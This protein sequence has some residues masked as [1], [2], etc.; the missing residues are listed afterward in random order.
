MATY[1]PPDPKHSMRQNLMFLREYAKRVILEG[2]DSLTA[3]E[4]VKEALI[5]EVWRA[6]KS[7]H[8]TERDVMILLY[9]GVLP[10]CY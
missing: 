9:K 5:E 1:T 3:L 6:G 8:L 7:F 4:D 10:E 2:D